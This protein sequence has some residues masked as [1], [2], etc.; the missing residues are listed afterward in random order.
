VPKDSSSSNLEFLKLQL[1]KKIQKN[2]Q[3]K[4]LL[5]KWKLFKTWHQGAISWY[6]KDSPSIYWGELFEGLW[7]FVRGRLFSIEEPFLVPNGSLLIFLVCHW[8]GSWCYRRL[9]GS[10]EIFL[11]TKRLSLNFLWY[12]IR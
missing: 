7:I 5:K 3:K 11:S 8:I 9:L 2:F 4:L 6:Q 1:Q 10:K 12:V